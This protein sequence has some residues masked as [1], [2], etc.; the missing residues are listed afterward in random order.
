VSAEEWAAIVSESVG[1]KSGGKQPVR[2]GTGD[3]PQNIEQAI[4]LAT[5]WFEKK[6]NL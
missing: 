5:E 3:K 1:G 4:V 6:L 2:Q